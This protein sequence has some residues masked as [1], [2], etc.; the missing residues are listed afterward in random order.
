[1]ILA[2]GA[3][4]FSV[5]TTHSLALP[6][7]AAVKNAVNATL[8]TSFTVF[9]HNGAAAP[10]APFGMEISPMSYRALYQPPDRCYFD[11]VSDIS[12]AQAQQFQMV[13]IGS[14]TYSTQG[15]NGSPAALLKLIDHPGNAPWEESSNNYYDPG[16][17][18]SAV[19]S[20]S[21]LL[22]AVS[23]TRNGDVFVVRGEPS[24]VDLFEA[25]GTAT[26]ISRIVIKGGHVVSESEYSEVSA[27]SRSGKKGVE[28][29]PPETLTYNSFGSSPVAAPSY[30]S[31][32]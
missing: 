4:S 6:P 8:D 32:P 20:L 22:T 29:T 9:E 28:F 16:D 5:A 24:V 26:P 11:E 31:G 25:T 3:A 1:M 14:T 21:F 12:T 17:C 30:D 19:A 13:V 18:G 23:A 7:L 27:V 15:K 2:L 10:L